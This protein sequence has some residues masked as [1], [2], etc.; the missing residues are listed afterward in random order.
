MLQ[1]LLTSVESWTLRSFIN[2]LCKTTQKVHGRAGS[3]NVGL[4]QLR[5]KA[6]RLDLIMD[7]LYA[8]VVVG[9]VSMFYGII[10]VA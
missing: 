3:G 10:C 4:P 7:F 2:N 5:F 8:E 6:N 9:L 1:F